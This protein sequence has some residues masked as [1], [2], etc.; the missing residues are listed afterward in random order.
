MGT[1]GELHP[2]TLEALDA[3][4][5]HAGFEVYL[6][7]LPTGKKKASKTKPRLDLSDLQ[8]LTRDFAFIVDQSVTSDKILRAAKG[9]DKKLITDAKVF[10]LF[11]GPSLGEGKNLSRL[12]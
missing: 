1:F 5:P 2:N 6:D 9:A 10:D 7:N 8:A 4:G 11:E 12:S 3:S